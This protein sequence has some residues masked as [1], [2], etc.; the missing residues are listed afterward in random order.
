MKILRFLVTLILYFCLITNMVLGQS[1][2]QSMACGDDDGGRTFH[3]KIPEGS[4]LT[5][6]TVWAA[7]RVDGIS[8][9]YRT[10]EGNAQEIHIGGY[11]G[12]RN[13]PFLISR[14]VSIV[15]MN[16]KCADRVDNIQFIFSDG[17]ASKSYGG[18]GGH[19]TTITLPR[20]VKFRG[21]YGR[22]GDEVDQIGLLYSN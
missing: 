2:Y 15:G 4:Q 11:G 7:E 1:V 16:L 18:G 22:H 13:T 5:S 17:T 9:S 12:V 20:D 8:F 6:I 21:F 19:S 3:H 14:N 10:S